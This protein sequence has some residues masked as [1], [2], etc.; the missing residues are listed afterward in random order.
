MCGSKSKRKNRKWEVTGKLYPVG[1]EN[2]QKILVNSKHQLTRAEGKISF[3]CGVGER[4]R[5]PW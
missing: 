1:R 3:F 4:P 5:D 2:K